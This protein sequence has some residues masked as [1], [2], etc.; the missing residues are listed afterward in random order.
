MTHP[1]IVA[2]C[3]LACSGSAGEKRSLMTH[4][5][6]HCCVALSPVIKAFLIIYLKPCG[7]AVPDSELR[8]RKALAFTHS[9]ARTSHKLDVTF[10]HIILI[11]L[12]RAGVASSSGLVNHL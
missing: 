3:L 12:T 8:P 7:A 6:V 1:H 5:R 10:M 2:V 11:K 9:M 4:F